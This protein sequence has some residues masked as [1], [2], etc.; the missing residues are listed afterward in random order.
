MRAELD[1]ANILLN[2]DCDSN[3]LS[4]LAARRGDA[5]GR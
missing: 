4:L 5:L 2:A 1:H 3:S